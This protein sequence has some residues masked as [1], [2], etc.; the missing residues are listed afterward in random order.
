MQDGCNLPSVTALFRGQSPVFQLYLRPRQGCNALLSLL[1]SC[2][3][4]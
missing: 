4:G 3:L 1:L 2:R